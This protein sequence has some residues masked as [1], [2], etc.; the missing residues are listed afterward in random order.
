[1]FFVTYGQAQAG[2][3]FDESITRDGVLTWQSQPSQRLTDH[4]IQNFIHHDD[5]VDTIYLFLRTRDKRPYVYCGE[6]GNLT[7]DADRGQPVHFQWQL[8]DWPLL[9]AVLDGLEI[10]PT[11][12]LAGTP[13]VPAQAGQLKEVPGPQVAKRGSRHTGQFIANK[14]P[15]RPDR[16]LA[17]QRWDSREKSSS[18]S[19]ND[20][21]ALL[22]HA[23]IS[24]TRS[25]TSQ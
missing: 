9:S 8:M 15:T 24:R 7:H 18:F 6:L 11:V 22:A 23:P 17:T 16:A 3:T 1:V 4:T 2:H 12:A 13:V 19:W 10:Q 20:R 21:G 14:Q 5:R 25:C